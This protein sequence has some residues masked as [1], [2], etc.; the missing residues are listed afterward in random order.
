M[1]G[2]GF[3]NFEISEFQ[4]SSKNISPFF[5]GCSLIFLDLIQIILSNKIE[6]LLLAGSL[7]GGAALISQDSR[8]GLISLSLDVLSCLII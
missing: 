5:Q 1:E 4:I 3:Q 2:Y 8:L 6:S 7:D